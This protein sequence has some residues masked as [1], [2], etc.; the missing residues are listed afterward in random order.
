MKSTP[1]RVINSLYRNSLAS[2]TLIFSEENYGIAYPQSTS[3]IANSNDILAYKEIAESLQM[4]A[5]SATALG[6]GTYPVKDLKQLE[7]KSRNG[8]I[9]DFLSSGNLA[10]TGAPYM[11]VCR[12]TVNKQTSFYDVEHTTYS[13]K[14]TLSSL[15]FNVFTAVKDN[16]SNYGT[17]KAIDPAFANTI[18]DGYVAR[19]I[20]LAL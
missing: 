13:N 4:A 11:Q 9:I 16:P 15:V 18:S 2:T 12:P 5:G 8:S 10:S 14:Y 7:G 6:L 17:D 19:N 1:A 3:R 20:R